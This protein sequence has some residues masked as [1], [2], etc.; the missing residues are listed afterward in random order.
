[1]M[2]PLTSR[3]PT[4]TFIKRQKRGKKTK[5]MQQNI[6]CN[7]YKRGQK[8]LKCK[9]TVDCRKITHAMF[10]YRKSHL[11]KNTYF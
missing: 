5:Q 3:R 8:I 10:V 7:N 2:G 1:M 9:N 4:K 11:L 6:F